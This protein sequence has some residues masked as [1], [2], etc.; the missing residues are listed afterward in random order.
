LTDEAVW[1]TTLGWHTAVYY[2]Y[3]Q[4]NGNIQKLRAKWKDETFFGNLTHLW[5]A[6]VQEEKERGRVKEEH[7]LEED[8]LA[9]MKAERDLLWEPQP[10]S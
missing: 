8:L 10:K 2:F 3:S 1:D 6:Y 9:I 5:A 4:E 7:D